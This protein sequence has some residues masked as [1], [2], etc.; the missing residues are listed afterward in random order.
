MLESFGL[1]WLPKVAR[2]DKG[3]TLSFEA[4]PDLKN[5]SKSRV[6]NFQRVSSISSQMQGILFINRHLWTYLSLS[7]TFFFVY[8][9]VKWVLFISCTI[10]SE[11]VGSKL[12]KVGR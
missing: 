5:R 6:N 10:R 9:R 7:E 11:A 8:I 12:T 4:L 2:M 3:S 1:F